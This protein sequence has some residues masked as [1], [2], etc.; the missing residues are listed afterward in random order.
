MSNHELLRSSAIAIALSLVAPSAI[1][2]ELVLWVNSPIASS[3]DAP[4]YEAVRAF[5]EET[6]HSVDVQAVA[7]MEM[8]RNLFVALSSGTGPDV[9]AVDIAWV[10]GLAEAG[11]LADL[12]DRVANVS[13]EYLSGPL[14][15]G[16]FDGRQYALPLYT[17]NV[18]LYINNRMFEEAGLDGAPTTW[19]EFEAA[20]IALTDDAAGTYGLTFGGGRVGAFQ[21]YP[22]LWQNGA[23]IIDETG[24]IRVGEPAAIEAVDFISGI[25]TEHGAMPDSVLT[26]LSWDEVNAPFIQERAGMLMSGDWAIGALER[27]GTDLDYSIH[28]L[29]VGREQA[30]V[31]G[32]YNMAMNAAG[33]AQDASWELVRW[34]TGERSV[35]LMRK[36]NRLAA[37]EAATTPE[38]LDALPETLRPFMEQAPHGRARPVVAAWSQIHSDVFATVWD[39]VLRGTSAEEAMTDAQAAIEAIMAE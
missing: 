29:P 34:L 19:E 12:S 27:D 4:L 35:E 31:I 37:V 22:F 32:G 17:N 39:S 14:S 9:M 10:A 36:Y 24:A 6:G 26:A 30:T 23:E 3:P 7:H 33:D 15:T 38:A 11:L 8:E 20:A 13:D 5:E 2:E 16:Q 28:P 25:Y 21:L 1:A 18:A